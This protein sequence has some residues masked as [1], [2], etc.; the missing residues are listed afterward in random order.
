MASFVLLGWPIVALFMHL[1]LGPARGLIWSVTIGYLFL[2]ENFGFDL[3]G[4]PAYEKGGAL[5]LGIVL[6]LLFA[7][8]KSN[9]DD[10][11][12]VSRM[13]RLRVRASCGRKP[14]Y[15]RGKAPLAR[16]A[17][18][19]QLSGHLDDRTNALRSPRSDPKRTTGPN[20]VPL[21]P[22]RPQPRRPPVSLQ[23]VH[24]LGRIAQ[25]HQSA[26]YH[27]QPHHIGVNRLNQGRI[28]AKITHQGHLGKMPGQCRHGTDAV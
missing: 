8:D 19:K 27:N 28:N 14:G 6:G 10:L 3:P 11:V 15:C 17:P 21:R 26:L 16:H 9:T 2:P 22:A 24:Q 23:L 12:T 25:T 20:I 18:P 7:R 4:L 13:F 5:A 1:V